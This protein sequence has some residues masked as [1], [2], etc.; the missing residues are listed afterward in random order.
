MKGRRVDVLQIVMGREVLCV[1]CMLWRTGVWGQKGDGCGV[2]STESKWGITNFTEDPF[3]TKFLC[4]LSRVT[5]VSWWIPIQLHS[6][7]LNMELNNNYPHFW[8]EGWIISTFLYTV[9]PCPTSKSKYVK[10]Q[11]MIESK[12]CT[13]SWNSYFPR[14]TYLNQKINKTFISTR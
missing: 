4:C 12:Y 6:V 8:K 14:L 11:Q 10:L 3:Y 7:G 5:A 1:R 2:G 13:F 9:N